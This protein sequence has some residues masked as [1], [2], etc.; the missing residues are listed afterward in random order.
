MPIEVFR[1]MYEESQRPITRVSPHRQRR[2]P[3]AKL[4]EASLRKRL[5]NLS[6]ERLFITYDES[7]RDIVNL[8]SEEVQPAATPV[9]P[10]HHR[11]VSDSTGMKTEG[12]YAKVYNRREAMREARSGQSAEKQSLAALRYDSER[13]IRVRS[14]S[15]AGDPTGE[16]CDGH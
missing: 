3:L 9:Q 13:H 11:R 4:Q 5:Q 1:K 10:G 15:T 6:Q 8:P 16:G 14:L 2:Q 12:S 7:F